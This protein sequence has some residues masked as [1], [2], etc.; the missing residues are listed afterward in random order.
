[1]SVVLWHRLRESFVG[2]DVGPDLL[3]PAG[4]FPAMPPVTRKSDGP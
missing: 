1:M 4:F 3:F 2:F